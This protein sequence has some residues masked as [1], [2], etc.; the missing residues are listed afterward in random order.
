MPNK[1]L[2][3]TL[4]TSAF[5]LLDKHGLMNSEALANTLKWDEDAIEWAELNGHEAVL[6]EPL[7]PTVA[8]WVLTKWE[9]KGTPKPTTEMPSEPSSLEDLDYKN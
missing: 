9:P 2:F 7:A 4:A 8:A 5:M 6:I 3:N 1:T